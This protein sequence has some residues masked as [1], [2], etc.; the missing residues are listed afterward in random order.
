MSCLR[1]VLVVAGAHKYILCIEKV[2][3]FIT[4]IQYSIIDRARKI[5]T[6][7]LGIVLVGIIYSKPGHL[8]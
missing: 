1:E 8:Y 7:H 5:Q 3:L 2:G 4:R 6:F